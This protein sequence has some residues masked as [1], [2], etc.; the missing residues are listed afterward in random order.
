MRT[1]CIAVLCLSLS[2]TLQVKAL[3]P[4]PDANLRTWVNNNFPGAIVG[5]SIDEMHPGVQA[6]TNLNIS[7]SGN[8]TNL[9]G[10]EA[11]SNATFMDVSNNPITTWMGPASLHHM[12]AYNCGITGTFT[13]PYMLTMLSVAYNNITTLDLSNADQLLYVT[14]HHNQITSVNWPSNP[15][16]TNV[17]L[18]YNQLSG[19]GA[20]YYL[21]YIQSLTVSHNQFTAVPYGWNNL[22]YLDASWNQITDLSQLHGS[23][24][25]FYVNLSHNAIQHV[26]HLSTAESV[27]LSFNP[28]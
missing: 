19:F 24:Y 8:V 9:M 17:D 22:T 14:A 18:S 11:F 25:N 12:I 4:M 20:N 21:P 1:S 10:M 2:T 27:D 6:A 5:T 26:P 7:G 28:L 3:T 16:V 13:A 15:A 23:N